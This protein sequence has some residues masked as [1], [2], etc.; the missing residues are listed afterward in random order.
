MRRFFDESIAVAEKYKK[1]S[2]TRNQVH[3][4]STHISSDYQIEYMLHHQW[5]LLSC[6]AGVRTHNPV[7]NVETLSKKKN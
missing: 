2:N 7:Q 1:S 5:M 6:E 4:K 3:F